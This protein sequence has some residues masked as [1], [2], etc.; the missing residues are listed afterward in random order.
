MRLKDKVAIIT[1][2]S[3]KGIG[4]AVALG[5]IPKFDSLSI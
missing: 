5:F 2:S 1:G 3:T 4:Y